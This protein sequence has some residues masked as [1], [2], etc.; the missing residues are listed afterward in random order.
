ML[1]KNIHG[2]EA[3]TARAAALGLEAG[4]AGPVGSYGKPSLGGNTF[5]LKDKLKAAGARWNG[6]DKVWSFDSW[7]SLEAAMS[8]LEANK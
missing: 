7:A 8:A 2:K 4:E 6:S 1:I 5:A 3:I